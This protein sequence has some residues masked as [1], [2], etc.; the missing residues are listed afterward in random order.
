MRRQA[1]EGEFRSNLHRGGSAKVVKLSKAEKQAAVI[2]AK[3]MGLAVAGVDMLPS[4]RGPLI[5]E[6]NSSPGLEGIE[7]ATKVDIAGKIFQFLEKNAGKKKI[8]KDKV[9]A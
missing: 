8:Q 2:A 3:K 1:R 4:N 9:N 5:L 7:G 6:V